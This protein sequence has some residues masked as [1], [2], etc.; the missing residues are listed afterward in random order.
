MIALGESKDL[1]PKCENNRRCTKQVATCQYHLQH[2]VT[3]SKA[4]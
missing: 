1:R 2:K 4:Y 3:A